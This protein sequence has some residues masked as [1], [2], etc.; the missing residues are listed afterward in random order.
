M[1]NSIKYNWYW[2]DNPIFNNYKTWI[3]TKQI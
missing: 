1:Y 3:K 2:M